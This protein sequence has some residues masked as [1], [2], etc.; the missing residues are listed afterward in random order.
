MKYI[1]YSADYPKIHLLIYCLMVC[2]F[3]LTHTSKLNAQTG[4]IIEAHDSLD[5][6]CG[7]SVSGYWQGGGGFTYAVSGFNPNDT[8]TGT[9]YYGDGTYYSCSH[10]YSILAPLGTHHVWNG[11]LHAYYNYGTYDMAF[12]VRGPGGVIDS[13]NHP[14]EVIIDSTC[15]QL[16]KI[17][18]E[19]ANS[20]CIHD[21]GET[22][23]N[24]L[25]ASMYNGSSRYYPVA[26]WNTIPVS[27]GVFYS[28][29]VDPYSNFAFTCP[30]GGI[31]NFTPYTDTTIYFA[32]ECPPNVY[33]HTITQ[34]VTKLRPFNT[35]EI[36]V[37][38][39]NPFCAIQN[40]T[41]ELN[42]DPDLTFVFSLPPPSVVNGN[43]LTW[44]HSNLNHSSMT[45]P[46]ARVFA[47][48][49][50]TL[51]VGDSVCNT[52]SISLFAGDVNPSNNMNTVCAPVVNSF[53][54]NDKYVFPNGSGSQGFVPP[55]TEFTYL[56]QFQNT[57]NDV[58]YRVNIL[59]TLDSDLDL[60][61]FKVVGSSHDYDVYFHSPHIID[62]SFEGINLPDSNTN[63]PMSH[64]F[65]LYSIKAADGLLSGTELT[66][67]A[68]IYFDNNAPVATRLTLNTISG[69]Q[70]LS[71]N[72]PFEISIIPNPASSE[73]K[74]KLDKDADYK[75]NVYT[76]ASQQ[77]FSGNFSGKEYKLDVTQIPSGI[78]TGILESKAGINRFRL[79]VVH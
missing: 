61:S 50:T 23:L 18:Y 71:E 56:I 75:L 38:P 70:G 22:I 39:S 72:T 29:Q 13:V 59:D 51:S 32:V 49:L 53:D 77:V 30:A 1:F 27:E 19:D 41:Y 79:S 26:V 11:F 9:I 73:L 20:N 58:A 54:P 24:N 33:D 62:F 68:H 57:G 10:P 14:A 37:Y 42:L 43:L 52:A 8:I 4:G 35:A 3:S 55:L 34:F 16:T 12:V 36:L 64:G 28:V 66:N 6:A 67:R 31:L 15:I 21:P 48:P 47:N 69:T 76:S 65:I 7:P 5:F 74:I 2:V 78:Y 45:G 44:N 17:V 40:G 46:G 25:P 60:S 63:E